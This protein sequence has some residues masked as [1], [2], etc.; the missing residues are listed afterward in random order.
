MRMKT[1]EE[2]NGLGSPLIYRAA[3]KTV[4]FGGWLHQTVLICMERLRDKNNSLMLCF[5]E[6][7]C[8]AEEPTGG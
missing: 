7:G 1:C 4:T 8:D 2:K 6:R 3:S 5:V